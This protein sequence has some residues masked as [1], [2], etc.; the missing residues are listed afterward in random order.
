MADERGRQGHIWIAVGAVVAFILA[1]AG[2]GWV[3]QQAG[4]WASAFGTFLAIL[5]LLL[6]AIAVIAAVAMAARGHHIERLRAH[7]RT[8]RET[9]RHREH[10]R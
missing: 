5:I 1:A 2:A 9:R 8:R 10:A 7:I 3:I 6:I 4:D